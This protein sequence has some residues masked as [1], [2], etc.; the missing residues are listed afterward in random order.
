MTEHISGNLDSITS[1]VTKRSGQIAAAAIAFFSFQTFSIIMIL[2]S[3]VPSGIRQK[4]EVASGVSLVRLHL[5]VNSQLWLMWIWMCNSAVLQES[6]CCWAA[7]SWTQG[8]ACSPAGQAGRG[9]ATAS[10]LKKLLTELKIPSVPVQHSVLC[11]EWKKG[12][13]PLSD[14]KG[15]VHCRT[16]T[17]HLSKESLGVTNKSK[18]TNNTVQTEVRNLWTFSEG[19]GSSS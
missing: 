6:L 18:P 4:N 11:H 9:T 12:P 5:R 7:F 19:F 16:R 14:P 1:S 8:T 2:G 3:I 13:R 15:W 17:P 10:T